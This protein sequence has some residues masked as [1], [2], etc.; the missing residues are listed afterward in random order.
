MENAF[1]EVYEVHSVTLLQSNDHA[2][3]YKSNY[4]L[5]FTAFKDSS[6]IFLL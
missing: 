1:N 3:V 6:D 5:L 2:N 4:D